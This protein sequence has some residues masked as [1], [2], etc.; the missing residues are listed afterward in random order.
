MESIE[1]KLPVDK[2]NYFI[3]FRYINHLS[4]HLDRNK[5]LSVYELEIFYRK[6]D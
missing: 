5:P 3:I 6:F 2:G 4:P 1:K